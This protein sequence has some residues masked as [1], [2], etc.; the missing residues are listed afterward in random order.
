MSNS[1]YFPSADEP[2]A[3]PSNFLKKGA[4]KKIAGDRA[5][6]GVSRRDGSAPLPP[7]SIEA[8]QGVLACVFLSPDI[9]MSE[10]EE[11]AV[12]EEWFYDLKHRGIWL[13]LAGMYAKGETLEV[14]TVF[15]RAREA[16]QLGDIGGIEYLATLPDKV[17]S[18]HVLDFHLNTVREK[19]TRR[20]ILQIAAGMTNGAYDEST[21]LETGIVEME[22][23][24]LGLSEE[25]SGQA[26][27]HIRELVLENINRLEDYH[28][29]SAQITGLTTGLS[30][31]DK[32][33]GGLGDE[34]GNYICVAARPGTGKTSIALDFV[35]HAALNHV[36]WTA[37]SLLELKAR[38]QKEFPG[39]ELPANPENWPLPAGHTLA[40]DGSCGFESHKG[41]P[42][43]FFSLEMTAA[44][45]VRRA[46]FQHSGSDLQ[47]FRTGYANGDD[48]KKLGQSASA[49]G[50]ANIWVDDTSRLTVDMFK[51]RARRLVRQH[52]IRMFALDYIQLMKSIRARH[53]RPDRTAEL[54]EISG[55]LRA[56][57]KELNVPLIILGQLNR[58][59]ER[60]DRWREPRS[61]D[62]KNCGAIEQDADVIMLLYK[63]KLDAE[64]EDAW[65]E[66][67]AVVSSREKQ[68]SGRDWSKN[69]RRINVLV[70]KNRDGLTGPAELVFDG[71]S[72]HFHDYGDWLKKH[73]LR[74]PAAGEPKRPEPED[75][76]P[77]TSDLDGMTNDE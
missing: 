65:T 73:G 53:Q 63:P 41:I 28:R 77:D 6:F 7:H 32:V 21:D 47:R 26:E 74:E 40:K 14:A 57:S 64:Q 70:D 16:N 2:G 35:L 45:L 12:S 24:V 76:R 3:Q 5:S 17:P 49:L 51:A 4:G 25:A 13:L 36:W 55:E 71:S 18:V 29:G 22:K 59:V 54:E 44:R 37:I 38:V 27:K 52:G 72:T 39:E 60:G 33:T 20:C 11:R 56:L 62:I 43:A 23:L 66:Q 68:A 67:Q 34:N 61:S 8:E 46:M 48:F 75:R 30:Y 69:Y 1:E 50:N 19:W 9:G 10:C 31:L 42:C 15:Q 58:D